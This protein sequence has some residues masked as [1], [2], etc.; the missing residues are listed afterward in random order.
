[1]SLL[2]NPYDLPNVGSYCGCRGNQLTVRTKLELPTQLIPEVVPTG[3][4]L[5]SP[6]DN[7][8]RD[9]KAFGEADHGLMIAR[10][11]RR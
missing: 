7:G 3:L 1:M 8:G 10:G 11:D 4:V 2:E 9:T 5:Q 6:N